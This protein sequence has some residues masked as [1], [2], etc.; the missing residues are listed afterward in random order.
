M[1]SGHH[2]TRA[3]RSAGVMRL[4]VLVDVSG[5]SRSQI[6]AKQI[7]HNAIQGRDDA[8]VLLDMLTEITDPDDILEAHITPEQLKVEA[9]EPIVDVDIDLDFRTVTLLF[10]PTGVEDFRTV[11]DRLTGDEE[12]VALCDMEILPKFRLAA[13]GIIERE[14][15]RALGSVVSRMCDIVLEYQAGQPDPEPEKAPA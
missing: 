5:L 7:A 2:R 15:I 8:S 11:I 13:Q 3:S 12:M 14:N 9:P 4:P 6:V 10:L 1:I